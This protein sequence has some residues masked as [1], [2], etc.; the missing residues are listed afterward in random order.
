MAAPAAPAG[1]SQEELTQ[2]IIELHHK[3]QV[4]ELPTCMNE[5]GGSGTGIGS[6]AGRKRWAAAPKAPW[7]IQCPPH[8]RPRWRHGWEDNWGVRRGPIVLAHAPQQEGA[9]ERASE[10]GDGVWSRAALEA[11][12]GR[13][14]C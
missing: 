7:R 2:V 10:R 11:L 6:R 12:W 13:A 1:P 3:G 14:G 9:E 8:V 5:V 4:S